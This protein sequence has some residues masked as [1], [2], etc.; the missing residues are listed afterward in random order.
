MFKPQKIKIVLTGGHHNSALS[1][2][3]ELKRNNYDIYWFGHK[4]TMWREKSISLEYKEITKAKIPF[5]EIK[6]GKFFR[7]FNPLQWLKIFS[8]FCQSLFYLV[9]IKPRLIVSFGGYISF[10]VILAAKVLGIDFIIHEQTAKAGLANQI[11]SR[12]AK[13]VLL[14]W[15]SSQKFFPQAKT[16]IIGLPLGQNL[17][18]KKLP[19]LPFTQNLPVV[20]ITGGKQGSAII[21]RIIEKNLTNFLNRYNLVHQTGGILK[22]GDF[23]RL[24]AKKRTLPVQL[25]KRYYLKKFFYHEE[26]IRL[27]KLANLVVSRSGAHI[28]YE[29]AH[30]AK[31]AILIPLPWSYNNEQQAN[32]K[33]LGDQ[34]MVLILNQ[35]DLSTLTLEKQLTY[36]FSHYKR[37][38]KNALKFSEEIKKDAT[39]KMVKI[40]EELV[41]H[42]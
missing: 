39:Q 36:L 25:Q 11:T 23:V 7:T 38:R 4:H 1:V 32:A 13:K 22:T 29:L 10:P 20:L 33:L 2:G 31:P 18:P 9:K 30:L 5:I 35:K 28:T 42:D 34:G 19:A 24:L 27:L 37:F 21:N 6:T 15:P 14:T 8:G 41:Y 16:K 3:L 26:M 12:W 17:P 40:I